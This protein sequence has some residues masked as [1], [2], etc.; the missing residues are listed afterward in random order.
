MNDKL[1]SIIV[2]VWNVEPYLRR[3]LDSL[4]A[5][6]YS[7]LEIILVDDGSTDKSGDICDEYAAKDKRIK[8]IHKINGGASSARNQA[9]DIASGKWIWFVD[10]DDYVENNALEVLIQMAETQTCDMVMAGYTIVDELERKKRLHM[11]DNTKLLSYQ[12][13]LL[14][15]FAPKDYPYQGY[16][17]NKL[18][19]A[20]II[21]EN[22]LR[23]EEDIH[24]NEDRL[25]VVNYLCKS[26]DNVAYTTQPIYNYCQREG[27]LMKS[28]HAGYD[29]RYASDFKAYTIMYKIIKQTRVHPSIVRLARRGIA[30]SFMANHK[31]MID[32][33]QLD[34]NLHKAMSRDL[35]C[36]NAWTQY[37]SLIFKEATRELLYWGYPQLLLRNK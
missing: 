6:T 25:F 33:A 8:V 30:M 32:N 28:S 15:M 35:L 31:M 12:E 37:L 19:R 23:F 27:S 21:K 29:P 7:S 36:T 2:A 24:F 16:V 13:G 34:T 18:F 5:Q 10:A 3:C 4:L 26:M 22:K 11:S 20:S 1:V 14:E 17:W 9:I